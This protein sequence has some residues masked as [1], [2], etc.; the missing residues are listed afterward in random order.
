M[1]AQRSAEVV[2]RMNI[3]STVVRIVQEMKS[4]VPS[5]SLGVTDVFLVTGYR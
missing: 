1:M 3:R 4:S 2:V 5:A